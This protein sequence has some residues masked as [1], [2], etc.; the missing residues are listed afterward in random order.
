MFLEML[1]WSYFLT[2]R[3]VLNEMMS[4]NPS[5]RYQ[6]S[7]R[8][9]AIFQRIHTLACIKILYAVIQTTS[10]LMEMEKQPQEYKIIFGLMVHTDGIIT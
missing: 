9:M 7:R 5:V 4:K 10:L 1:I 6:C 2:M 3:A 8:T